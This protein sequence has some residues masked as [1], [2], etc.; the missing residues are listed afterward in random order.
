MPHLGNSNLGMNTIDS[1]QGQFFTFAWASCTHA[2][3]KKNKQEVQCP[4]GKGKRALSEKN[5]HVGLGCV[6]PMTWSLMD[7]GV[8]A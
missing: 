2:R 7:A 5:P 8:A 4:P 1:N 6:L 3:T